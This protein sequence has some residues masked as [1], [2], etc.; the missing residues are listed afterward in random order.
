VP[1][2]R[3]WSFVSFD[4]KKEISPIS[5]GLT[6]AG[7]AMISRFVWCGAVEF[8]DRA[9]AGLIK[10][11]RVK[12]TFRMIGFQNMNVLPFPEPSAL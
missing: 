10:F 1:K 9:F 7:T 3:S 5:A 8:A 11:S 12:P 4:D 6:I 2:L